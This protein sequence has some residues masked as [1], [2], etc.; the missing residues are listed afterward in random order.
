MTAADADWLTVTG[1]SPEHIGTL[2]AQHAI[3]IYETTAESGSLEDV[4]LRLT[5]HPPNA[6]KREEPT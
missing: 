6:T 2:A 3:P 5:A 4:F 1:V